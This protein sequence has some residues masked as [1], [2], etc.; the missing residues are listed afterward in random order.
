[1]FLYLGLPTVKLTEVRFLIIHNLK[2]IYSEV[3]GIEKRAQWPVDDQSD[4]IVAYCEVPMSF[5]ELSF[6]VLQTLKQIKQNPKY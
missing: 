5:T 3:V 1:M 4:P 6:Y 2:G